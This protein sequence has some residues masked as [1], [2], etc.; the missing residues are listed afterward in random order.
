[1][2]P[3]PPAVD[4]VNGESL[5]ILPEAVDALQHVQLLVLELGQVDPQ[6]GPDLETVR[7]SLLATGLVSANVNQLAELRTKPLGSFGPDLRYVCPVFISAVQE[8][9]DESG[10]RLNVRLLL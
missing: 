1:M 4:Q 8:D 10:H 3:A 9:D 5:L 2:H 7:I 6:P